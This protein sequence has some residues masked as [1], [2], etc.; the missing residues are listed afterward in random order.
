[1]TPGFSV[2]TLIIMRKPACFTV[3]RISILLTFLLPSAYA[4][5]ALVG[6]DEL[7]GHILAPP[8][9]IEAGLHGALN[10]AILS[11]VGSPDF[12]FYMSASGDFSKSD[13]AGVSWAMPGFSL[14][15]MGT[16][17]E[18]DVWTHR[19]RVSAAAG[20]RLFSF[21]AGYEWTLASTGFLDPRN[22][23]VLGLL[24][25]PTP[26]LSFSVFSNVTFSGTEDEHVI[27][28]G[29]RPL[30]DRT[31][32]LFGDY[33]LSTPRRP[34]D[35]IAGAPSFGAVFEA[36]FFEGLSVGARF[37]PLSREF[38]L[39]ARVSFGITALTANARFGGDAS[40]KGL[41]LAYRA[42]NVET[43]A[44][45]DSFAE[46]SAYL[47]LDCSGRIGY[48]RD[49]FG[50]RKTLLAV[51][52][53]I[54][55][56]GTDP[57]IA[58]I[59]VNASTMEAGLE[60]LWEIRERLE[61]FKAG[62]KKVVVYLERADL[63][64]LYFASVADRIVCDPLA[65]IVLAGFASGST[66]YKGLLDKAGIGFDEI[67]LFEY[68]S[69]NEAFSRT[70]MSEADREQTAALL[71]DVYAEVK[72]KIAGSR[73]LSGEEFDR[74][75]DGD[76]VTNTETA[77]AEKLIDETGRWDDV[78]KTIH[79]LEGESMAIVDAGAL[80]K[81]NLPF[82]SEWGEHPTIAV[83]YATGICDMDWGMNIRMLSRQVEGLA[84]NP[85][86]AAIV[87][88]IDSP[89]GS[90]LASDVLAA[91]LEKARETKPVVVSLGAVAAS[92]GYW[93]ATGGDAILASP[94]TVTGSIGVAGGWAYDNGLK[95]MLGLA[96]DLV[97]IGRHADAFFGVSIPFAGI[98]LPDRALAQDER[99]SFEKNM[100]SV[101]A[102]FVGRVSRARSLGSEKTEEAARGRVWSGTDAPGLRLADGIGGL[103]D[104][105]RLAAEKA[106][107]D[108]AAETRVAEYPER[109]LAFLP[110]FMS[111][112]L[113]A[114]ANK[115]ASADPFFDYVMF[116]TAH[117]GEPLAI[118]DFDTYES[119][120]LP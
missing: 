75:I 41:G 22:S 47:E 4:Q 49:F 71:E 26:V 32:T 48:V 109:E 106:G 12:L 18:T 40:F 77:I 85:F 34:E 88:R 54:D 45:A 118:M 5:D 37:A 115:E 60:F 113:G 84:K 95:R 43:G 102:S 53:R 97:K 91:S 112:I 42:G 21:G 6:Y 63:P 93:I 89:G 92:G 83:V 79:A 68:K 108:P 120:L 116:R 51:L 61:A 36:P 24:V 17:D 2:R 119:V 94:V 65:T 50:T 28:I 86:V 87:V 10:P 52:D 98:T 67:R 82:H 76:L 13:L 55:T 80:R 11:Y 72:R 30:G 117:N 64:L 59:V 38:S 44:I 57:T 69:A 31:L 25:R 96:T 100:R 8:D 81:N 33:A 104:A 39:G 29:V 78:E 107:L 46:R 105:I 1:M 19:M 56:A 35:W 58:G 7:S 73:G 16:K 62:G 90:A 70:G 9:S 14:G 111:D 110:A 27:G 20:N 3:I 101:Y 114:G 74:I 99:A 23:A 103:A 66:Y 15:L